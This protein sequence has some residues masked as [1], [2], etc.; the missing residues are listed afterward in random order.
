MSA[1]QV[2]SN[3]TNT[4]FDA[5]RLIGRK[6]NDPSIQQDIKHWPFKVLSGAAEKPMIEGRPLLQSTS[7]SPSERPAFF[8]GRVR[9]AHGLLIWFKA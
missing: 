1:V 9:S 7:F 2:A 8:S 3:P 4:V 5:K 6:Y